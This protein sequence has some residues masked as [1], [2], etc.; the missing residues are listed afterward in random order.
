MSWEGFPYFN[1]LIKLG[2]K[3][4]DLEKILKVREYRPDKYFLIYVPR[5]SED[6]K[7][8]YLTWSQDVKSINL[9]KPS[10]NKSKLVKKLSRQ[11][12]LYVKERI[13]AKGLRRKM[14]KSSLVSGAMLAS[15]D[16][17]I[18]FNEL[19][20]YIQKLVSSID[21]DE[22]NQFIFKSGKRLEWMLKVF[23]WRIQ[24]DLQILDIDLDIN[25][26]I[27]TFRKLLFR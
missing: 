11:F 2:F 17:C 10:K 3:E 8:G 21:C 6:G 27:E 1:E 25:P 13:H 22:T 24:Y 9:R 12:R 16:I 7:D 26:N 18:I 23:V 14:I 20:T 19:D 15:A 4:D 5:K